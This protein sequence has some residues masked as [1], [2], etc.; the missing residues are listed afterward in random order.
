MARRHV[1]I[2]VQRGPLDIAS[3]ILL[4]SGDSLVRKLNPLSVLH[5][6]ITFSS[7]P[8]ETN[9]LITLATKVSLEAI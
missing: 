9:L 2:V 4:A 1:S 6:C 5:Y 7:Y 8:S 3:L